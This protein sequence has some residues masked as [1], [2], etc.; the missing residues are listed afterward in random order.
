MRFSAPIRHKSSTHSGQQEPAMA[1]AA[2]EGAA[3][4]AHWAKASRTHLKGCSR[5]CRAAGVEFKINPRLVRG[6][7]YYNLT[8]IEVDHR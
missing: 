3:I 8:V 1:K 4:T 7:D 5:C 2:S 6:L